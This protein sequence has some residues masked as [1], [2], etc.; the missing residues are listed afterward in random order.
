MSYNVYTVES[1]G[2]G[3]RNHKA[4]YI[5]T[6]PTAAQKSFKGALYH[7]TGTILNGMTYESRDTIDPEQLPE[8]IPGTKKQIATIAA[9]DLARFEDECCLTVPPPRAQITLSGKRLFP[10]IPLY[11]CREWLADVEKVAVE[12]GIFA[13]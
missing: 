8:H 10:Q 4:I 11:R 7:V 13:R 5:E 1:L 9:P 12:K 3:E 6:N 2:N